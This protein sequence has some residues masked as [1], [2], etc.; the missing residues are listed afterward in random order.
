MKNHP[1]TARR[2][3]REHGA[4]LV[5]VAFGTL[6]ILGFAALAIDVGY[7]YVVRNELQNAADAAVLGGA[8]KLYPANP[9][10]NWSAAE[11]QA[12]ATIPLNKASNVSLSS[13]TVETG[14]WNLTGTP[15]GLQSKGITPGLKD[16][17]AVRVTLTKATGSNGGPVGTFLGSVVGVKNM[18]VAASAV[19]VISYPGTVSP[20]QLFPTAIAKCLYDHYWNSVTNQPLTG[21][22]CPAAPSGCPANPANP[23]NIYGC[24]FCIGSAYH[25]APCDSGEWTS[26]KL[27]ENSVPAVRGLIEN[28]NPDSISI[29]E[30]IWIEP[31]TKT[32][33]Y[34]SVPVGVTVLLPVVPCVTCGKGEQPVQAFGPFVIT[35]S[36]GGSGKYIRGHFTTNYKV[37]GGSGGGPNYGAYTPPTLVK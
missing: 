10:P 12:T 7:V 34:N 11:T 2:A 24:E 30:D 33:L 3:G 13:G 21:A 25:Y 26:F 20:G 22:A 23:G 9:I 29:G 19:A 16:A 5:L 17:A 28:G 27:D 8:G 35:D 14:Y 6:I 32:T 37:G 18:P 4:T 1:K 15:A 36:V 31:G